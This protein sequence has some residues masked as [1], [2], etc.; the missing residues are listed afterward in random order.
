LILK[1]RFVFIESVIIVAYLI[2]FV[3]HCMR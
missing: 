3:R 1:D 2:S